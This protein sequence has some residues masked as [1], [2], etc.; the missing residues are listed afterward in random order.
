M[1]T[2]K[3][4]YATCETALIIWEHLSQPEQVE[5]STDLSE[6]YGIAELRDR[7]IECWA[8]WVNRAYDE[9]FGPDFDSAPFDIEIV[10][11]I[12]DAVN[13]RASDLMTTSYYDWLHATRRVHSRYMLVEQG[14]CISGKSVSLLMSV[15]AEERSGEATLDTA[16]IVELRNQLEEDMKAA[17]KQLKGAC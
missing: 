17:L 1:K 16:D 9:T 10:P 6:R 8:P 4:F 13:N 7:N 2:H 14:F 3:E 5:M 11:D 15:I 12:I